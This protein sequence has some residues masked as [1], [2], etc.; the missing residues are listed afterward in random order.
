MII[1]LKNKDTLQVDEFHFKCSIGKKG[2]S[3]EKYEGDLKT[4]KGLYQFNTLYFRSDRLEKPKTKLKVIEI[5]KNMGWCNDIN[6]PKKYNKLIKI[7]K[8]VRHEKMFRSDKK[9]DFVIPI[10]YNYKNPVENRGSAIFFHLT[11]SY[12]PTAG[13]IA[14]NLND[15]LIFLKLLD[16]ENKI[17]IC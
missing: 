3:Q 9:Y 8:K 17:K 11:N 16:K 2:L 6:N 15:F 7:D 5:K 4:P 1:N 13:C 10:K 12:K 14:L